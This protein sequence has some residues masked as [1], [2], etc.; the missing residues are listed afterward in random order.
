MIISVSG[1][2][3]L[4]VSRLCYFATAPGGWPALSIL[5]RRIC[6]AWSSL[7]PSA[8]SSMTCIRTLSGTAD[9]PLQW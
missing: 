4:G 2:V 6:K 5:S 1:V 7:I 9:Q 3:L 8:S